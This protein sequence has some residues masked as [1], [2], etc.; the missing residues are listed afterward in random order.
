ML[1]DGAHGHELPS[2]ARGHLLAVVRNGQQD[3]A[4]L[5][6]DGGVD[7]PVDPGLHRLQQPLRGRVVAE[8]D[9]DPT[10]PLR[11]TR[12]STTVTATPARGK[13]EVS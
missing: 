2:R 12:S 7:P 5:V 6:V 1:G 3:G 11:L 13:C 10:I 4:R 9:L 8:D